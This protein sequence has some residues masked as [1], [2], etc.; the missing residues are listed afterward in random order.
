MRR[1][2]RHGE[3]TG[4]IGEEFKVQPK[5][6]DIEYRAGTDFTSREF[7]RA[8]EERV[9]NHI[10]NLENTGN[11]EKKKNRD[12]VQPKAKGEERTVLCVGILSL[13]EL[14]DESVNDTFDLVQGD[15]TSERNELTVLT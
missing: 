14:F 9:R 5:G 6:R 11:N 12:H 8:I 7:N 13:I 10:E 1:N 2:E 3:Q 15:P 4:Y